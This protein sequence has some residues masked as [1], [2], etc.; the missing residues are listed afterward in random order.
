MKQDN[1]FKQTTKKVLL[2]VGYFVVINSFFFSA[3]AEDRKLR[4][5]GSDQG[6]GAL[7]TY[8]QELCQ[9]PG[10]DRIFF[11]INPAQYP[12][13]R[14][15]LRAPIV[16]PDH[17]QGTLSLQMPKNQELILDGT[18]FYE[19][20]CDSSDEDCLYRTDGL[21]YVDLLGVGSQYGDSCLL[22][23]DSNGHFFANISFV[24]NSYGAGLC[25][26]GQENRV[27]QNRFG[28]EE[29]GRE[30][31]NRY[32]IIVSDVYRSQVPALNGENNII[33][34]NQIGPSIEHGLWVHGNQTSILNN[35]IT[36]SQNNSGMILWNNGHTIRGNQI[37][38][39]QGYGIWIGGEDSTL[40]Q[41]QVSFNNNGIYVAPNSMNIT[42]G[43]PSFENNR[44][45]IQDNR[46]GGVIVVGENTEQITITHN[47]ISNNGGL[48]LD[49]GDD[50]ITLNDLQDMDE[51]PNHLLNTMDYVQ[52]FPLVPAADGS[53]RYWGF[54]VAR[55]GTRLELYADVFLTDVPVNHM[56]SIQPQFISNLEPDQSITGLSFDEEG[57]TSEFALNIPVGPDE[58][59]DGIVDSLETGGNQ[60]SHAN[61]V[62]SDGDNLPDSVEDKNR[63]GTWDRNLGETK[64]YDADTDDDGLSDWAETHG[65][66]VYDPGIDTNPFSI[67]SDGDGLTDEQEDRN[68]NGIVDAGEASPLLRDSDNDS[69]DDSRDLCPALYGQ[70][71]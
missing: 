23:I 10:N 42:L 32:G 5:L 15:E 58:D 19:R 39:N 20:S 67:D 49:L 51:G 2:G 14:M 11:E 63:N 68:G 24:G 71:C 69:I 43:G 28:K 1:I 40:S 17:C 48:D 44:N 13:I 47:S 56:F 38:H 70:R 25:L 34:N 62:D 3:Y 26:F 64:S 50:G 27:E 61:N 29:S 31:P 57:N 9:L 7:R 16:I 66:G 53:P 35:E 55:H 4:T 30:S 12:Q 41:N 60:S 6:E 46:E 65:D 37:T 18:H 54:G 21:S 22:R 36:N 59:M 52:A 8:I 45:I 33:I